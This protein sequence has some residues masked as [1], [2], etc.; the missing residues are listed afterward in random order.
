VRGALS[1]PGAI[2]ATVRFRP[3]TGYTAYRDC[4][5]YR[6]DPRSRFEGVVYESMLPA[7]RRLIAAEEGAVMLDSSLTIDH[8]GYDAPR[9]HKSERYLRLLARATESDPE[10]IY[11]WWH[12][13]SIHRDLGRID[14][15]EAC[16]RRGLALARE[17]SALQRRA[18]LS[19]R[20]HQA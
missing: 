10:R 5:L 1:V 11:L 16:W 7:V 2:A 4:P 17:G 19:H 20:A 14:K 3:R 8:V 12:P 9:T 6:R 13:G 15:A 18:P